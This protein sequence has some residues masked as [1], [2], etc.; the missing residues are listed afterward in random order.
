MVAEED[1]LWRERGLNERDQASRVVFAGLG[2][3]A[4]ALALLVAAAF[5]V[6]RR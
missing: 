2:G 3:L 1:R 4:A 6:A 5:L